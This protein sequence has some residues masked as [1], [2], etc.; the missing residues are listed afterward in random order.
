LAVVA[1][2]RRAAAPAARVRLAVSRALAAI[3]A[4]RLHLERLAL[5]LLRILHALLEARG[6]RGRRVDG[7][8]RLVDAVGA[9]RALGAARPPT[10]LARSGAAGA[11]RDDVRARDALRR[12]R[13]RPPGAPAAPRRT[14]GAAR[15][16]RRC[17]DRGTRS[18]CS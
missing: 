13:R 18:G 3:V 7:D 16:S 4:Q 15:R 10:R 17:R 14:S 5:R 8:D 12:H 11:R 2:R 9:R 6:R 1:G